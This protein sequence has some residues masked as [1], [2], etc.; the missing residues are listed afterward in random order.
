MTIIVYKDGILAADSAAVTGLSTTYITPHR[1]IE[2]SKCKRFAWGISGNV[3]DPE[4]NDEFQRLLLPHL[5]MC[6]SD[7]RDTKPIPPE[8]FELVK[9]RDFIVMTS[10]MAYVRRNNEGTSYALSKLLPGEFACIG[11]GRILATAACLAG[12]SAAEAT[13]FAIVHDYYS[14]PSKVLINKQ[15]SLKPLPKEIK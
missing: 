14:Y 11:T 5:I 7:S 8:L 4:Y 3:I 2:T 15:S 6:M 9:G 13:E 12:R 1:K 10:D